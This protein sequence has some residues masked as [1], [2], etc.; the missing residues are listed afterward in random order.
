MHRLFLA[1]MVASASA[2]TLAAP[3]ERIS[4][5][6]NRDVI[7]KTEWDEMVDMTVRSGAAKTIT[8][9]AREK[10]GNEVLERMI[11]DKLIVQAAVADGL[12]VSDTEVAPDVDREMDAIRAGFKSQ[13]EF[14][15]QLRKEGLST[16]DL[17]WRL[18]QR[19]RDRYLYFKMLNRKQREM[20]SQADITEEEMGGYLASHASTTGWMTEPAIRA[21]H[22]Q[23]S[24]DPTLSGEKKKEALDEAMKKADA[25]RSALK[26]GEAFEDV[27]K[28]M[29]EDALTRDNGGDMGSFARG[30]F[31]ESIEK[32]AFSLKQGQ[33]SEPVI[34]PAGIHIIRVEEIIKPR[35]RSLDEKVTVQAPQVPG[36]TGA[37][38]EEITLREHIKGI[39]RH[40]KMSLAMQGWVDG[41]KKSALIQHFKAE[42]AKP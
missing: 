27:A 17:R 35:L 21:R 29:S 40:Q 30:T 15:N 31:N 42:P 13:K 1:I 23:F 20:E 33:I 7:T 38:T 28:T 41:L 6:V 18:T 14:E 5:R 26:R 36:S 10:I 8:A 16:E 2:P 25:A 24:I 3:V 34:S 37:E 4:A 12:K 22:I 39:L 32:A 19:I 9:E 11:A